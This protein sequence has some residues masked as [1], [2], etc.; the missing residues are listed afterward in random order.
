MQVR[1]KLNLKFDDTQCCDDQCE[2]R[3]LRDR[4]CELHTGCDSFQP[5]DVADL[6]DRLLVGYRSTDVLPTDLW[7]LQLAPDLI[8]GILSVL[9]LRFA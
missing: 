7:L 6:A 2:L 1:L 8:R 3:E 4:F 5:G 9:L